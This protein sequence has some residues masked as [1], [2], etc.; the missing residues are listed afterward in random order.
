MTET[1]QKRPVVYLD[2]CFVSRL[3]GWVSSVEN[4]VKKEQLATREVWRRMEGKVQAVVSELVWAE[5]DRGD[6]ACAAQRTAA[7]A[8][9]P[10]WPYSAEAS[11]L[12]AE[13]LQAGAVR[14]EKPDDALH[15]ALAAVGGADILLSWNFR[16]IANEEK[17]SEIKAI[18]ERSGH[19][20][21]LITSPDKLPEDWP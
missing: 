19:R 16:D 3:T 8:G 17:F 7:I 11:A 6:P 18:V 5:I 12:A 2:A 1:V 21:P 10:M 9:L 4:R 20:C 15:I 13:L 14:K